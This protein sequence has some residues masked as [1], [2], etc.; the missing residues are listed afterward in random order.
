MIAIIILA[1]NLIAP[2][3]FPRES[4][5]IEEGLNSRIPAGHRIV[6]I[7]KT[8]L[9]SPQDVLYL[10]HLLYS[11]KFSRLAASPHCDTQLDSR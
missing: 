2:S 1:T 7:Q 5:Q 9:F 8:Q 3:L 10:F 4:K 11:L 6:L